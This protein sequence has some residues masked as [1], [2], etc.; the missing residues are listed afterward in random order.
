MFVSPFF[1]RAARALVLA[2]LALSVTAC[3]GGGSLED[4]EV[5]DGPE[6]VI[7]G[8]RPPLAPVLTIAPATTYADN[9]AQAFTVLNTERLAAGVGALRQD[10][11]LDAASS[12][13]SAYMKANG[14]T[15][16][17][18][19]LGNP[20]FTGANMTDRVLAA[21]W[22]LNPAYLT[23]QIRAE[24]ATPREAVMA[25]LASVYKRAEL[26]DHRASVAGMSPIAAAGDLFVSMLGVP[27]GGTAQ[28]FV[29]ADV[30]RKIPEHSVYPAQGALNVP[31]AIQPRK[32][33]VV[34][35]PIWGTGYP[36]SI[37]FHS[38]ASYEIT[39]FNLVDKTTNQRVPGAVR[40]KYNDS[41]LQA[42]YRHFAF[43][44]P[45]QPLLPGR[46]YEAQVIAEVYGKPFTK[47]W[48][49]T[50]AAN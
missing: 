34:N 4:D 46:T 22:Q 36:V 50:T 25:M 37:Q 38:Q 35:D 47:I 6:E 23:E 45:D 41:W 31:R 32:P 30:D 5:A 26:L 15:S 1:R 14:T 2:M 29:G 42:A 28:G 13:H 40:T 16:S 27:N 8:N 11:A 43:F 7:A 10:S 12:A 21:G 49:F 19:V 39:S 9:R 44:V 3:G 18:E 33:A 20:G 24:S 17:Q 48:S